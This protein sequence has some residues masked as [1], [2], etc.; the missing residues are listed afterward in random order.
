MWTV[1]YTVSPEDGRVA[2]CHVD[3]LRTLELPDVTQSNPTS[4][5]WDDTLPATPSDDIES[6]PNG[7]DDSQSGGTMSGS[8]QTP[9]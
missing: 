3:H 1:L 5:N 9:L 7:T 6:A 2:R 8:S 4:P